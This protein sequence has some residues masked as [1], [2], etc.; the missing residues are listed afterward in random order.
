MPQFFK[1]GCELN[2]TIIWRVNYII[3]QEFWLNTKSALA[4]NKKRRSRAAI[5]AALCAERT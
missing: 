5:A 1:I 3:L 4:L 2:L